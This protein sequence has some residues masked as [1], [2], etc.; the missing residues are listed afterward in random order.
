MTITREM[1]K[2]HLWTL[3]RLGV[4]VG[5]IWYISQ[6]IDF[7]EALRRVA[8][9]DPVWTGLAVFLVTAQ[10]FV[11]ALRWRFLARM[12]GDVPTYSRFARFTIEGMFFN[13]T[14]PSSVGG[15]AVRIY[16]LARVPG[17]GTARAIGSVLLDRA[18]GLLG[19]V[20]I[21]GAALAAHYSLIDDPVARHGATLLIAAGIG[22]FL[23]FLALD[24]LPDRLRSWRP[25]L[26]LLNLS[27]L[28]R[29]I[30]LE[31]IAVVAAGRHDLRRTDDGPV[32]DLSAGTGVGNRRRFLARG[33]RAGDQQPRLLYSDHH[34]RLGTA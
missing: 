20:L 13:Q 22:G 32:I 1:A 7:E 28:A 30:L 18:F 3:F 14:L 4:T 29:R 33:D 27:R 9:A 23:F 26:E 17:F 6:K 12:T 15:D 16:R 21:S 31:R 2:R 25:V 24:A 19:L 10:L 34:R 5:L 11:I 8:A